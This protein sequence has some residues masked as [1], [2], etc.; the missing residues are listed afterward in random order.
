MEPLR[1]RVVTARPARL[2]PKTTDARCVRRMRLTPS[3]IISKPY[4][5]VLRLAAGQGKRI[6]RS[7]RHRELREGRCERNEF[8][9]PRHTRGAGAVRVPFERQQEEC[10]TMRTYG[11]SR[12]AAGLAGGGFSILALAA[13]T[14]ATAAMMAPGAADARG[15]GGGGFRGRAGFSGFQ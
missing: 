1:R 15:F 12:R 5:T 14:T 10:K 2:H 11:Y 9:C 13:A 6:R 7:N 8:A 3:R 4:C